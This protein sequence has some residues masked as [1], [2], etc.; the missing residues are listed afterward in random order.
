[1]P[2]MSEVVK[3]RL[4]ST[5]RKTFVVLKEE[6]SRLVTHTGVL[7]HVEG[8]DCLKDPGHHCLRVYV[9]ARGQALCVPAARFVR[10]DV[11]SQCLS[12]WRGVEW[13]TFLYYGFFALAPEVFQYNPILSPSVYSSVVRVHSHMGLTFPLYLSLSIVPVTPG[14]HLR[15]ERN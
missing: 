15:D 6:H 9:G 5:T 14:V 3:V 4:Q 8:L 10:T 11:N 2:C 12:D 1:M 7:L 13:C